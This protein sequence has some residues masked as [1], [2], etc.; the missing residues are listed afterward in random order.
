MD[1]KKISELA[2]KGRMGRRDFIQ[3]G[4]A[5][6]LSATAASTLFSKAV[7]AEPKKGGTFRIALGSGATTDTLD[8]ATYPDTFN[9]LFGWGSLRSS[10]TEVAADGSIVGD[11]AESF[12][13][14]DGAKTWAFK[15]RKGIEFHN[16]KSVDADDVVASINHHR[17]EESKSAAKSLLAD[18]TDVKADGKDTVIFTLKAGNADFPYISS[19]YHMPIMP[20]KDG[21]VEWQSGIGTGPYAMTTFEPGVKGA[22][23]RFANYHGETWFD[24]IEVLSVLDVA[25]R[26]NALVS[27]EVHCIDRVDLKTSNLLAQTPDL[28]LAEVAGFAH[29]VAPM[30]TTVAPFDNRDVRLAL[31]YAINR[32]EIVK[33]V[34]YGHGSPGNDNP[35][36]PGVPF[37]IDPKVKHTYDPDKAKFHL[38]QAGLSSLKVDLSAADAAFAGSVDAALLMKDAAAAAGIDI[39]VVREP[40]DGYWDNVWM[41]KPWCMS[42][43]S[44]RPT[45]D[46]MFT[47]AYAADAAW[48]DSF[49]KND[50]FNELLVYARSETDQKKRADAYAEM[51]D[52]VAEDGGVVVLMFY[53]Y[54]GAHSKSVAHPEVIAPNWDVDGMK[55][56][57]RWWFA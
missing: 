40:D 42:Y 13:P 32:E 51:Q 11:V 20:A 47:T 39:N 24:E 44:G 36:A 15:L 55:I 9:G 25:A 21:K 57:K 1:L 48:N 17:S 28:T 49:W 50:R 27:G 6:G 14:G 3:F 56:T 16:G 23:K 31:K 45:P 46:L 43:W 19:D 29:Y 12:E 35:I 34:L 33:K 4:L 37:S 41:K 10:L 26:T 8:P 22:A 53:N 30:N 5:L 2:A 54:V 7:R 18:V 38:K 52:I